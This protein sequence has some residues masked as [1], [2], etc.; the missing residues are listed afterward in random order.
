MRIDGH[1]HVDA[2]SVLRPVLTGAVDDVAGGS[3]RVRFMVDTGADGSALTSAD[4]DEL[5]IDP[6]ESGGKLFGVAGD[7]AEV[8]V[9]TVVRFVRDDGTTVAFRD[10]LSV[11]PPDSPFTLSVVGRNILNVFA[12]IVDRPGDAVTLVTGQH[13]YSIHAS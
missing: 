11:L 9:E 8:Y 2:D 5:G 1:W 10:R 12:V 6:V 3:V 4:A 7:T 13:R